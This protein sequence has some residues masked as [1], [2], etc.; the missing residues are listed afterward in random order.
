MQ[1][2][3]RVQCCPRHLAAGRRRDVKVIDC[4]IRDGGLMNNWEFEHELVK[5]TFR[6]LMH[7]G[8]DIMEIGYRSSGKVF[9]PDKFGPWRF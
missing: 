5:K 6:A 7:V 2:D 1:N 9:D 4:T 8:V 3:Y